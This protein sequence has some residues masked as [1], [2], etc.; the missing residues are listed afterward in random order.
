[1]KALGRWLWRYRS[2]IKDVVI[3][4][5]LVIILSQMR[6]DQQ[7]TDRLAKVTAIAT[8]ENQRQN[9]IIGRIVSDLEAET[10]ARTTQGCLNNAERQDAYRNAL[11]NLLDAT[12]PKDANGQPVP[13][14]AAQQKRIDDLKA[15]IKK[16]LPQL[17]CP[18]DEGPI[19][20]PTPSTTAPG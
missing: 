7:R 8:V 1:M 15:Q 10:K 9:E 19:V 16:D 12:I 18:Q 20:L 2:T 14:P 5:A 11:L 6:S 4:L 17:T 3:G 13:L